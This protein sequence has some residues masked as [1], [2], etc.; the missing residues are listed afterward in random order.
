M[1]KIIFPL[2][3]FIII[4][5]IP[6]PE[7]ISFRGWI[8]FALFVAVIAALIL[9]PIPSAAIG[10]IGV[11]FAAVFGLVYINPSDACKWALSGFSNSTIWLIFI[12]FMFALAF[13]KTGLGKRIALL[14]IRVFGKKSIFLGYTITFTNFLMSPFIPTNTGRNAGVIYPIISNIPPHFM[15]LFQIKIKAK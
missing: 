8:Y 2:L 13:E 11:T 6:S 15:V 7:S 12:G 4:C 3:L 5:F 10:I 14:L 1:K 9:E